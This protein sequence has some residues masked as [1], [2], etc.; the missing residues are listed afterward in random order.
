MIMLS[1]RSAKDRISVFNIFFKD[2]IV[3]IVRRGLSTL[4]DRK[5]ASLTELPFDD[6]T[7]L[8]ILYP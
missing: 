2:L 3:E 4:K 6:D 1:F 5:E 8:G 7:Q